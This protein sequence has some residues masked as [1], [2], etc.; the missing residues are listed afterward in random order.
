MTHFPHLSIP[1]RLIIL[2]AAILVAAV[3]GHALPTDTYATRSVLADG[4]WVKIAVERSGMVMI[5]SAD[6]RKWGFADP[7]AVR[8]YGYGASRIPDRLDASTYID[9]LPQTPS[10]VTSRGIVFY[11]NGPENTSTDASGRITCSLNPFTTHAYYFL[12]D[13]GD[14][15]RRLDPPTG[16]LEPP[17]TWHVT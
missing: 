15:A 5:G 14:D 1:S 13:G 10:A 4:R 7:G 9:D 12:T 11:A 6:L 2:V 8:V 17:G 3:T 16:G